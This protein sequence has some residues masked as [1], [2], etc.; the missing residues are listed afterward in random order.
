MSHRSFFSPSGGST[1]KKKKKS[2][3][4]STPSK[5][6]KEREEDGADVVSSPKGPV[7]DSSESPV[8]K[9]KSK[10]RRV[11]MDSDSDTEKEDKG[12][13]VMMSGDVGVK[14]VKG[15][16]GEEAEVCEDVQ[17]E[18]ENVNE[19]DGETQCQ[20]E[21]MTENTNIDV[22]TNGQVSTEQLL[23][24]VRP[25]RAQ[26]IANGD[27]NSTEIVRTPPKRTTGEE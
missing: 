6:R 1:N 13:D 8:L 27:D 9:S 20:D 19:G 16:E 26:Q 4:Q 3:S 24:P 17:I 7:L 12:E 14:E 15:C 21:S 22:K 11:I 18:S 10:R 25:S 23:S 5:K 2:D